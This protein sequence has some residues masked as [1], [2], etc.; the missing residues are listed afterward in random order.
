MQDFEKSGIGNFG[1]YWFPGLCRSS[2]CQISLSISKN[3]ICLIL[4][5]SHQEVIQD[6]EAIKIMV[7]DGIFL[8]F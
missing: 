3:Y 6:W 7:V 5:P 1:K 2:K 4:T 8:N